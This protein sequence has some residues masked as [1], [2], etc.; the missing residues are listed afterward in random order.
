MQKFNRNYKIIFEIGNRGDN[1]QELNP[2]Q[3]IEVKYPFTMRMQTAQGIN[4]S[5]A[6]SCS[7]QLYN[8]PETV[9]KALYKDNYNNKKYILMALYAGYQDTMPLV[10][11]GFINQ[12]YSYRQGGDTEYIT[13]IQADNNSCISLYG[14]VNE[15]FTAGTPII[16]VIQ[17]M[18]SESYG[19]SL[20]YITPEIK[21]LKRDKTFIGQTLDLLGRE[22][23]GYDIFIDKGELNILGENDVIPA[24]GLLV[25]T[26]ESG[27]LGSPRRAGLFLIIEMLFEP[28]IKVGQAIE[29]LSDSIPWFNQVY[30]VQA[31]EHK[32]II[33]PVQNGQ[34]VTTI[35]LSL[36]E[37]PFNELRKST[38][39]EVKE[40]PKN[41]EWQ[42]PVQGGR[43]SS[44]Y[45]MRNHPTIKDKNGKP[46]R[47]LHDGVDI[48]VPIGTSVFAAAEGTVEFTGWNGGYGR[49]IRINHGKDA[50]GNTIQSFYGHLNTIKTNVNARVT[51]GQVIALSGNTA[52]TDKNGVKMTTGPHLHF[53]MHKNQKSI[54][55]NEYIKF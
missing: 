10:F 6:G 17:S 27:L 40:K 19:Y 50:A 41:I 11:Y 46:M 31:V 21:P 9:Q 4:L 38:E 33:S 8:L 53:G 47:L 28:R 26:S 54:N 34:L 23:G 52:G 36:G 16:N 29:L 37:T 12:C 42:R 7:I 25:I 22:Y 48:A 1:L 13:E 39:P 32:G 45:G 30:K 14:F 35:T 20:G 18:L 44:G 55:P 5:N 43:I 24:D 2:E 51:K 49:Y 15:T 3:E